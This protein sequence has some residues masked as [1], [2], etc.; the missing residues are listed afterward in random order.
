MRTI[1]LVSLA[2]GACTPPVRLGVGGGAGAGHVAS[3]DTR[4]K[5]EV[6]DTSVI[7]E[8]RAA[9]T[10]LELME[11]PPEPF[12][13]SLGAVFDRIDA[14]NGHRGVEIGP[15]AEG[16]WFAHVVVNGHQRWRIGPTALAETLFDV[17]SGKGTDALFD[18]YGAAAGV[19]VE[20]DERV[21]GPMF[22]GVTRGELGIGVA[23]RVGARDVDGD[24][25]AY[26]MLSLEV[27]APGMIA[28][29][30][31]PAAPR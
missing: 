8:F 28:I 20:F 26:A 23:L 30:L 5:L 15:F 19:L 3:V 4:Q 11:H 13:L 1:V 14:R 22:L 18:G 17:P 31:P 27:R 21:D 9:V 12:D 2:F 25:Y 6:H 7:T 29:P 10:P 24:G 16:V